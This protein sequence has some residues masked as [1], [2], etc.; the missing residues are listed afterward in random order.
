MTQYFLFTLMTYSDDIINLA[1]NSIREE[2]GVP[3]VAKMYKLSTKTVYRWIN[4]YMDNVNIN[5]NY[6]VTPTRKRSNRKFDR[7]AERVVDFVKQN[8]GCSIYDIYLY[9]CGKEISLSTIS[10]IAKANGIVHKRLSNKIICKDME[11]INED[12]RTFAQQMNY[13]MN[14]VI[15][16][17]EVSFCINDHQRYGYGFSGED[18]IIEWKHK[19]NRKR[20][21]TIAAISNTGIV[22]KK[23]VTGSINRVVYK[24]FLEE[25]L[26]LFKDK[27]VI[28][29]NARCHHA[30]IVKEFA[31]ENALHLKFNPP[32]SPEFNPIELAFNKI[33]RNYRKCNHEN[34]EDDINQ[35][36]ETITSIDCQGFYKH[37]NDF[38]QK[39][40]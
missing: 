36:F 8:I 17:D 19:Q 40:K 4:L 30:I 34:M 35:S 5:I 24:D 16:L 2:I 9:G 33:K 10:R 29:D 7:Y 3:Q 15:F 6:L 13:D 39:Y 38:I 22:A 27:I 12:R 25:N 28:Q 21:T 11:K 18:I 23:T 31:L 32:Y 1:L 14:D 37:S 20:L 26:E